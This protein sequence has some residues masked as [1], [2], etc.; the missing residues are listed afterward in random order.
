MNGDTFTPPFS[1]ASALFGSSRFSDS[2]VAIHSQNVYND[3]GFRAWSFK[4]HYNPTSFNPD[5]LPVPRVYS[6]DQS[7]TMSVNKSR[8]WTTSFQDKSTR[9]T[10]KNENMAD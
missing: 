2:D 7:A 5:P 8:D 10:P 4:K 3:F 6:K 1:E 9:V